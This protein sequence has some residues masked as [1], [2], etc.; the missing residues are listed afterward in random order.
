[1]TIEGKCFESIQDIKAAMT[2][3][4]KTLMKEDF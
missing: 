1:M 4:L 3:Q 2:V